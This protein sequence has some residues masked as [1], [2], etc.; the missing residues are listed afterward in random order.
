[1]NILITGCAGF[2]GYHLARKLINKNNHVIGIDNLNNYYDRNL[3]INRIK[4][5]KSLD[6]KNFKFLKIDIKDSKKLFKKL[7]NF[8]FDA[9]V[10]LAAQAGV[11][12]S[13]KNPKTY[14]DNNING[15]FNILNFSK[16]K[17]VKNL[18]FASTSSVYGNAKKFPLKESYDTSSPIQM[19]AATKKTN[20]LMAH[21]Y[22]HLYKMKITG[23]RFFTVYGPWGRPDMALSIFTKSIIEKK[24][25]KLF[26]YGNHIRDFTYVD[27]IVSGIIKL[28]Y[29]KDN[30]K[31]KFKIF[32]LGNNKPITLKKYI[33]LI[34]KNL[35]IKAKKKYL[36]LQAGDVEKTHSN[37]NLLKKEINFIPKTKPEKG[38]FNFIKWYLEYY[39]INL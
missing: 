29:K 35:K 25:I 36:P 11:R 22:S 34:E 2:I 8:K 27:D 38:I 1:M 7:K 5:L 26:N 9:V 37:T 32:N 24:T 30:S 21:A 33:L 10:N 14:I 12:Y 20:E 23:L 28:I 17:K 15:F 13:L 18:I 3:K 19:Y 16:E 6:K 31:S 39:K 4:N